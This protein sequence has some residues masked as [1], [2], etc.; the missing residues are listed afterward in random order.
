M[1]ILMVVGLCLSQFCHNCFFFSSM[2]NCVIFDETVVVRLQ[3]K[4]LMPVLVALLLPQHS[5]WLAGSLA[6]QAVAVE[7][8]VCSYCPAMSF[9]LVC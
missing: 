4:A 5:T 6:N 2:Q 3:V 7:E 1:V 9:V 8:G